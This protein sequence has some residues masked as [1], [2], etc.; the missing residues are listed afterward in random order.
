MF[1]I[2][3]KTFIKNYEKTQDPSVRFKYGVAAG[4]F[5][6]ITN[7]L[8]FAAKA[9]IGWISGSITI[10]ADAVN[11]LSDAG[12]SA[13][14][15]FAF[16]LSSKPA[17]EKHPYGHAR[18][19]YVAGLFVSF[20]VLAIGAM[21]AKSS[22]EKIIAPE[23]VVVTYVTYIVLGVSILGKLLQMLVYRDFGKSIGSETLIASSA[24]SRNDVLT[25]TAVLIASIVI[26]VTGVN[27]DGYAGLAVSAF[28]IFSGAKLI[29]E[30]I[31]PLLGVIPNEETIKTIKDKLLSYDGV[32]GIHD[33]SVHTY[34]AAQTYVFVHVEVDAKE[35]ALKSHD[36]IDN[37]ERDFKKDL[38]I[39]LSIHTDPVLKG[40]P[41][42]EALKKDVKD[43]LASLNPKISI[44]DFRI[45]KGSTHTNLVFDV[46]VPF[47]V[48]EGEKDIRAAL[49]DA[50]SGRET[51]YYFVFQI[52][53]SAVL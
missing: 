7:V 19:E 25:T 15:A 20:L 43:A 44:H 35:D 1:K 28:I 37:I 48:T 16:K 22:I 8:L 10:I 23:E 36:L 18:F 24:D 13:V 39:F 34:G 12:S 2:F 26:Q 27:I 9:V 14:T 32:L 38:G 49:T 41:E 31:D 42:T 40:D 51:D 30:T 52:D 33:L 21:L 17:D 5:G 3:K 46:L 47:G 4:V 29:K 6:I 50:F 45:I 11:N 53:R